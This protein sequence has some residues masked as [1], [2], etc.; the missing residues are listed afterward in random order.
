MHFETTY[1]LENFILN[2]KWEEV[3]YEVQQRMKGCFVDLMGALVIGS[4]S[5]QFNAGLKLAETVF[6]E[7]TS[8]SSATTRS[9]TSWA[10]PPPWAIL[11]MP[12]ISTTVTI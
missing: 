2:T 9:S 8:P 1:K 5:R 7:A 4:R 3:P 12:M 10:P 11:P 6:G